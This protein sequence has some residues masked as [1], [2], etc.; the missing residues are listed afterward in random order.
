[1]AR[2]SVVLGARVLQC[3]LKKETEARSK[4]GQSFGCHVMEGRLS[5]VVV[6]GEH[7][8]APPAS[9][10]SAVGV[11]TH[12]RTLAPSVDDIPVPRY[13]GHLLKVCR[14]E[15]G[16]HVG[17]QR[18]AIIDRILRYLHLNKSCGLQ[19]FS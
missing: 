3:K 16:I 2:A 17:G 4:A 15:E 14:T 18:R 10:A 13:F 12:C 5:S 11:V 7:I 8:V 6:K 1:L 19:E 9:F